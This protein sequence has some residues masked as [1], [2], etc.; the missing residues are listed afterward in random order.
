MAF[1]P[2]FQPVGETPAEPEVKPRRARKP[3][4]R[5]KADD[6]ST[7]DVT[8]AWEIPKADGLSEDTSI[9]PKL[10]PKG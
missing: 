8:E 7:P 2:F 9:K 6:P 3:S 10:E 5:F 1:N 4:G